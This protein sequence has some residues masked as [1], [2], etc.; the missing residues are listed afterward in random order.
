[1]I[2]IAELGEGDLDAL[3]GLYEQ[4]WGEAGS[5][6]K[7]RAVFRRLTDNPDYVFLVAKKNDV[8]VG[9]VMGIVCEELYGE[10]APFMVVEDVIVDRQH[11]REGIGSALMRALELRAEQRGCAY[12]LFVTERERQEAIDFYRSLGYDSEA[13]QGFKKRLTDLPSP[14]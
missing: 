7:M 13:Y 3:A 2:I 10:C 9:S 12:L 8:L 6:A 14:P 5:R 1:V 4:F 11:R